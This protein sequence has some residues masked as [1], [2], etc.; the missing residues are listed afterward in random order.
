MMKKT[1]AGILL[2]VWVLL[3]IFFS[4]YS[5]YKIVSVTNDVLTNKITQ[6]QA[7]SK[8][9]NE[10][11]DKLPRIF[12]ETP[13]TTV[14]LVLNQKSKLLG[15]LY[16]PTRINMLDYN[17][18]LK[19][20]KS[21][22]L[23][24]FSYLRLPFS[25]GSSIWVISNKEISLT[26]AFGFMLK[27][28]SEL[29]LIPITYVF[30]FIILLLGVIVDTSEKKPDMKIKSPAPKFLKSDGQKNYIAIANEKYLSSKILILLDM[31]EKNFS[32]NSIAFYSRE[33]GQWKHILEKTGNLVIK[34][35][36]AIEHLPREIIDLSDNSWREP[37][38]SAD[39]RLLF[40]PL[41]YRN[42]LF[43]LIRIQFTGLASEIDSQILDRL[44][45]LCTGYSDSL[46]MQRVYDKA[47]SDPETGFYNY[48]YFY[49]VVKE[50][51]VS[52]QN[53]AVVVFEISSLNTVSP[54]T[55]RS[56]AQDVLQ[57]LSH[58]KLKPVVSARLDRAKFTLL[59][60]IASE[61]HTEEEREHSEKTELSR[62]DEV[63]KIVQKITFKIF[64][65]TAK[66]TGGF[67]LRPTNYEDADSFLQRLD[68]L[69]I[70]SSFSTY[71][72]DFNG[73]FSTEQRKQDVE[74]EKKRD[75]SIE[76]ATSL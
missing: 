63:P 15:S 50:K 75:A 45:S 53:F 35:D 57:E 72:A 76:P 56:W 5:Y 60:E 74:K 47:V 33:S 1:V 4:Y 67:F 37:L 64:R 16:E 59:Y 51:L 39:K 19:T 62:L 71:P 17:E 73:K 61:K 6:I 20:Y 68:Y 23:K 25:F 22:E 38:L 69:L 12:N 9:I 26:Q 10:V 48:P 66:L 46:F 28:N 21:T 41:H 44:I 36:A 54:G 11:L 24:K 43:G 8:N 3:G 55:I 52:S 18:I 31:I 42:L 65:H 34:G 58:E 70:N 29:I 7:S 30:I 14:I 40:I 2:F 32:A 27:N 49:F 13:S